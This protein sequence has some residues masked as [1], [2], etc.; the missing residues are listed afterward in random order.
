MQEGPEAEL[1]HYDENKAWD[2]WSMGTCTTDVEAE[3]GVG[4]HNEHH[5]QQQQPM[6][7]DEARNPEMIHAIDP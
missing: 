1:P 7:E 5:S 3:E 6:E 4:E 2:A